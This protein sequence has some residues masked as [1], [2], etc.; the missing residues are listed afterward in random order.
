LDKNQTLKTAAK[1]IIYSIELS[2]RNTLLIFKNMKGITA[3]LK[4]HK[5]FGVILV[6][7]MGLNFAYGF[8]T[9]FTVIN[10]L[11]ILISIVNF[12]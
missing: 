1:F 6:G 8:D 5:R 12:D 7:V 4:T 11:W 2:H 10:L 3:Y 9:R